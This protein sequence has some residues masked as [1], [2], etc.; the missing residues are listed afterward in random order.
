M[1]NTTI[2]PESDDVYITA[3]V[4]DDAGNIIKDNSFKFSIDQVGDVDAT[5]NE[6]L[7]VYEA[8]YTLSAYGVLYTVS[9]SS[10]NY[11]DLEVLTGAFY[12]VRGTFTDLQNKI[13]NAIADGTAL[14]ELPYNFTY[15]DAVDGGLKNGIYINGEVT[16]DGNNFTFGT[17]TLTGDGRTLIGDVSN[18]LNVKVA[19]YSNDYYSPVIPDPNNGDNNGNGNDNTN[20]EDINT[21]IPDLEFEVNNKVVETKILHMKEVI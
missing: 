3:I 7:L 9:M 1:G 10:G 14:V 11:G 19:F 15:N 12:T 8:N 2:V 4:T 16:I 17:P 18:G 6:T 5:F 21:N 13:D 20:K